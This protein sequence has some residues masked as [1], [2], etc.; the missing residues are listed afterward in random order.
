MLPAKIEISF[1][2]RPSI[3]VLEQIGCKS[4]LRLLLY[5]PDKR[6][7]P[8]T[9][10]RTSQ[11]ITALPTLVHNPSYTG[12]GASNSHLRNVNQYQTSAPPADHYF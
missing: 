10:P 5:P 6:N 9:P 12:R 4:V 2:Y 8:R 7:N 3:L 1:N 11:W